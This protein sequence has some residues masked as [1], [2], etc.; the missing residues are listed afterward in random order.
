MRVLIAHSSSSERTTLTDAIPRVGPEPLEIVQCADG[1]DAL[2]VLL[3]EDAPELALVDWDLPG[4]E[5]P[6]MC[7]L[8]RD[9]HHGPATQM[10]ILASPEHEDT[11]DAWRAGAAQCFATPASASVIRERLAAGL[12]GVPQP[13]A[14]DREPHAA[15]RERPTLDAVRTPDAE[16]VNCFFRGRPPPRSLARPPRRTV[17]HCCRPCSSSVERL[18]GGPWPPCPVLPRSAPEPPLALLRPPLRERLPRRADPA[19][20]RVCG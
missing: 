16:D 14:A 20:V 13:Q 3:G 9:F 4:I 1:Y 11:A 12:R 18:K 2:D 17:P 8:V 10:V 6:E 19:T 5:G 15:D 7:R